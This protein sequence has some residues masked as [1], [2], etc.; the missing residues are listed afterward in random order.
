[1][2]KLFENWNKFLKESYRQHRGGVYGTGDNP[3]METEGPSGDTGLQLAQALEQKLEASG[4][5]TG[6]AW[7]SISAEVMAPQTYPLDE[8]RDLYN[9]EL[10]NN[11]LPSLEE[12]GL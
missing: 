2:K 9:Q 4:M 6:W 8:L 1:M 7:D 10:Q 12:M 5:S 3:S 11:M